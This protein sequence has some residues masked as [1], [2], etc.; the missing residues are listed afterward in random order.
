[1]Q[2]E[3]LKRKTKA[4]DTYSPVE[5]ERVPGAACTSAHLL[6]PSP[7]SRWQSNPGSEAVV[8]M[9]VIELEPSSSSWNHKQHPIIKKHN[10]GQRS[11]LC[12]SLVRKGTRETTVYYNTKHDVLD[13]VFEL[14]YFSNRVLY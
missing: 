1:M 13:P 10:W 12:D 2:V 9:G 4:C 11:Q 3:D 6:E 7:S 14:Y 5:M 8:D